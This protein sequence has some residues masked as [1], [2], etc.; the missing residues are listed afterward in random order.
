MKMCVFA[1]EQ[2]RKCHLQPACEMYPIAT[3][4]DRRWETEESR[5]EAAEWEEECRDPV[6]HPGK[7]RRGFP[8]TSMTLPPAG[9][10]ALNK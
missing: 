6:P 8:R 7:L 1:V 3:S 10:S 4:Q 5:G 2:K 9:P